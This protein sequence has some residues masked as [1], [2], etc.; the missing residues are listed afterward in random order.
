M[1]YDSVCVHQLKT[2]INDGPSSSTG[3]VENIL[4]QYQ[5]YNKTLYKYVLQSMPV[6]FRKPDK[7]V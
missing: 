1:P 6:M 5:T 3:P 7:I 4:D 2:K